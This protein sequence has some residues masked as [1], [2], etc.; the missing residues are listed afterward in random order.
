M[1]NKEKEVDH[2][3]ELAREIIDNIELLQANCTSIVFKA[4]RLARFVER[5][6]IREW[7]GY[8]TS[9]YLSGSPNI[10]HWV[11]V[12]GR[13]RTEND[14]TWY[15]MNIAQL[16]AAIDVSRKKIDAFRMPSSLGNDALTSAKMIVNSVNQISV[17]ITKYEGIRSKIFAEL[18]KFATSVYYDRIFAS[19]IEGIFDSYKKE[20]D[21]LVAEKLGDIVEK[22]PSVVKRLSDSDAESI[23]HAMTTCRRIIEAFADHIYPASDEP[24]T[25]GGNEASV[26]KDKVLNRINKFVEE[27]C[28][29]KS[30]RDRIRQNLAN[31]WGRVCSSVHGDSVDAWEAKNLFFNVYLIVGEIVGLKSNL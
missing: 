16:E 31:L 27:N 10:E 21:L 17:H 4:T 30:R 28:A 23:T 5:D 12:T 24:V 2:I 29:S 9:G 11:T 13:W 8:E 7:L 6:D 19:L 22:I 15:Q 3:T 18:H 1:S 26:K 14:G 25:L 20:I